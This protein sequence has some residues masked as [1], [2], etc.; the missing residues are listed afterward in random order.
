MKDVCCFEEIMSR[1][2]PEKFGNTS[3]ATLV[4][5]VFHRDFRF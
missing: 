1:K 2:R 5:N 3:V 4:C